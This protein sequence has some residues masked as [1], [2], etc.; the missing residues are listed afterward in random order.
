MKHIDLDYVEDEIIAG[1]ENFIP[2]VNRYMTD[3]QQN[4]NGI[5]AAQAEKENALKEGKAGVGSVTSK[6]STVPTSPKLTKPR[7]PRLP[8]AIE[9]KQTVSVC[10]I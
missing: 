5:A 1:V 4:A 6:A 7:P 8:E 10:I 2:D 9:I 3:L